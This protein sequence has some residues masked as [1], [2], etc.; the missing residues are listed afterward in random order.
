MTSCTES[1]IQEQLLGVIHGKDQE[2]EIP[3]MI[4]EHVKDSSH[5][6]KAYPLLSNLLEGIEVLGEEDSLPSKS[7]FKKLEDDS[8]ISFK[9]AAAHKPIT[10]QKTLSKFRAITSLNSLHMIDMDM[11]IEPQAKSKMGKS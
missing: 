1:R 9:K 6:V 2:M 7:I 3:F 8:D 10:Q 4:K 11:A 5:M